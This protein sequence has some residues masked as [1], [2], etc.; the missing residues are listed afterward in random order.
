VKAT[1][2]SDKNLLGTLEKAWKRAHPTKPFEGS[3]LYD[4]LH[5][6]KGAWSTVSML[7]FLASITIT[8]ACLG[9]L[10]MVVYNTETRR[11]EIGI[12][13]VMGASVSAIMS[14]LSRGFMRLVV[15]AGLIAL[16]ISY[17]LSY[18]FLTMFAN[19]ISIGFGILAVCFLGMLL[20]S[21]ITIGSHIYKVAIA[22]PV[23]ALRSE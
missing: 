18:F 20:I 7:G 12:R 3:W 19:R 4:D 8:L 10:G 11:K 2:E 21:L 22:N 17:A 14:L 6:R 13:K 9:L 16:P 1:T 15:I 23:N 5:E